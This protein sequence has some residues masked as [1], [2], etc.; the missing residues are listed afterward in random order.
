L[1]RALTALKDRG[2]RRRTLIVGAGRGGRSLLRELRETPGE[3]VVGFVDDD[4]H[5]RRR[6]L[7][8]VPV[9]GGTDDLAVVL[10]AS[11]PDAV[12]VTIPNAP[13]DRLDAAVRECARAGADCRFARRHAD[14]D[15][16]VVLGASRE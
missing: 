1:V 9:L 15:P 8:G 16:L 12:L 4:V 3:Q 7:Q 14:L 2:E 10:D 13:R 11:R 6:R 5:L